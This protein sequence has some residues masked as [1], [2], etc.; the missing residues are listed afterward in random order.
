M[1]LNYHR[2]IRFNDFSGVPIFSYNDGWPTCRDHFD[3]SVS[4]A[5][6]TDYVAKLP[7]FPHGT[8]HG[9]LGGTLNYDK[10]LDK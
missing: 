10:S 3:L 9:V 6:W 1:Y 2:V 4:Y 5:T 7:G 8:V